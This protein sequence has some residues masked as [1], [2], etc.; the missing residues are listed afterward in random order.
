MRSGLIC[1]CFVIWTNI[2]SGP[3]LPSRPQMHFQSDA[4]DSH[5]SGWAELVVQNTILK[6]Q[7]HGANMLKVEVY[8]P[9]YFCFAS[10]FS[11][12]LLVCSVKTD[13]KNLK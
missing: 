4:E 13:C 6:K 2:L 8:K 5:E 12:G 9:V 7:A 10:L 3:E 11:Q 1:L